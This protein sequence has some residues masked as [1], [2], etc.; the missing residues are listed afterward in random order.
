MGSLLKKVGSRQ[1]HKYEETTLRYKKSEFKVQVAD[2]FSKMATGLMGR[3]ELADNAGMLFIF[4]KEGRYGFW[5][6]NMKIDI[7]IIWLDG[8]KRIVHIWENAQPCKSIFSC[9][10]VRPETNSLYVVELKAGTA[11]RLRMKAG[12]R[13]GW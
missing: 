6:L 5:M 12:D 9:K 10:T 2:T 8:K 13:L 7:D 4:K 1:K 11:S 3:T